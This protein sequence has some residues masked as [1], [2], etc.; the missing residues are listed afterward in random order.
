MTSNLENPPMVGAQRFCAIAD[1][2]AESSEALEAL[3]CLAKTMQHTL[4]IEVPL[5]GPRVCLVQFNWQ[6]SIVEWIEEIEEAIR[7]SQEVQLIAGRAS[8]VTLRADDTARTGVLEVEARLSLYLRHWSAL[9]IDEGAMQKPTNYDELQKSPRPVIGHVPRQLREMLIS[10]QQENGDV[11]LR[12]WEPPKENAMTRWYRLGLRFDSIAIIFALICGLTGGNH[13][14]FTH[15]NKM[16]LLSESLS[17]NAKE[18]AG[19]WAGLESLTTPLGDDKLDRHDALL[20]LEIDF[21]VAH[22]TPPPGKISNNF[23][24]KRGG[25]VE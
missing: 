14:P 12:P 19:I 9:L 6:T 2:A 16:Q 18:Q 1:L 11:Y 15:V 17:I 3:L 5:D 25:S 7:T 8:K 13:V 4:G 20:Q 10:M 23:S 22:A 24:L 21:L